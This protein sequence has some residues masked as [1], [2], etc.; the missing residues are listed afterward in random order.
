MKQ[1]LPTNMKHKEDCN[2]LS[3]EKIRTNNT[4]YFED[5]LD[6]EICHECGFIDCQKLANCPIK[7]DICSKN[8]AVYDGKTISGPWAFM[9]QECMHTNGIGLGLGKG[10]I[11]KEVR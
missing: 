3:C 2:C 5:E 4:I 6:K 8:L 10:Q 9:C 7:C 11:L 1:L